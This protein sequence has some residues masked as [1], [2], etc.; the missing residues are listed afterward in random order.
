V[1]VPR[2]LVEHVAKLDPVAIRQANVD[3]DRVRLGRIGRRDRCG[4][5]LCGGDRGS[6]VGEV[7]VINERNIGSSST[8]NTL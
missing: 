1:W 3:Q 5:V 7:L 2:E 8:T 6:D 4:G